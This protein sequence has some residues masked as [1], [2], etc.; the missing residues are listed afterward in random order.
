M[1]LGNGKTINMQ[2]DNRNVGHAESMGVPEKLKL[3]SFL[4]AGACQS[5]AALHLDITPETIKPLKPLQQP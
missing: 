4:P 1:D 5:E 2:E 3:N